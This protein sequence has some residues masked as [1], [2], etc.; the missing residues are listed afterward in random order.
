MFYYRSCT[1]T[2]LVNITM[3]AK[4]MT[5]EQK[6]FLKLEPHAIRIREGTADDFDYLPAV[7]F[8]ITEEQKHQSIQISDIQQSQTKIVHLPTVLFEITEE[9]K[10]QSMQI[11][12]IQQ[13]QTKII[14]LSFISILAFVIIFGLTL[15]ILLRN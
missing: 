13:L 10:R 5:I 7:L 6:I 11:S 12:D 14:R 15:T 8:Q 9:Q 2:G 4:N 3:I 1:A